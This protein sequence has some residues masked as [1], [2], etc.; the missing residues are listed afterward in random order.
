MKVVNIFFAQRLTHRFL[1]ALLV[2]AALWVSAFRA[3]AIEDAII[4]VVNNEVITY[5]DL[6]DHLQAAYIR[7]NLEKRPQSE[8]DR[9][10]AELKS[11]GLNKLIKDKLILSEA[12]KKGIEVSEEAVEERIQEIKS[13]YP[14]HQAFL[15]SV[16]AGGY[17]L[18][19]MRNKI[20]DQIKIQSLVEA[21]VRSK[22]RINPQEV[23]DY[24][25]Q[26][27]AQF[28]KPERI[29]LDSI[30]IAKSNP[31]E[32]A[33]QKIQEA[34]AA[35][36]TGKS[37]R[38]VADE[39]SETPPIGTIARGEL[40]PRIEV[41]VFSLTDGEISSVVD[42]EQGFYIFK[43]LGKT[44][45]YEASLDEV[46]MQIYNTL[47]EKKFQQDFAAWMTELETHNYVEIKE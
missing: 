9:I 40:L 14:S 2:I 20:R 28:I 47:F 4:A 8:I 46:K 23:T 7:L 5:Q 10:M 32:E 16:T 39:Y 37:F 1:T 30:F 24:Y 36:G 17:T 3:F 44:L 31:P 13:Q 27:R 21:E 18:T 6:R 29:N 22:I 33:R 38:E 41:I 45:R 26:N 34:M 25:K 15:D 43:V 35:L 12:N 19:D 11:E 42:T